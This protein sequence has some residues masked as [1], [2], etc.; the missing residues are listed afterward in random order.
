MFSLL[1]FS[2]KKNYQPLD[3][4]RIFITILLFLIKH[5]TLNLR[6]NEELHK[7]SLV[8]ED[9]TLHENLQDFFCSEIHPVLKYSQHALNNSLNAHFSSTKIWVNK[10]PPK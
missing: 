9:I 8:L 7:I 5:I 6:S 4:Y 10:L 2:Y 1:P 3:L